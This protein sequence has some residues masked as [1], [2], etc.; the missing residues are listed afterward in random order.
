MRYENNTYTTSDN[1]WDIEFLFVEISPCCWRAYILTDINYK[2]FS[3]TRSDSVTDVHRLT[4]GNE[5]I[6]SKIQAF[7]K[8]NNIPYHNPIIRYI[9]W[10]EH[11]RTLERMRE[12]AKNWS[13]IT[14]YYIQYGGSFESIQKKL[15]SKGII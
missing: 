6:V 7:I 14:S 8:T 2:R 9:C 1:L 3:D 11:I 10:T 4:E 15:E 13:E 5:A 12:I